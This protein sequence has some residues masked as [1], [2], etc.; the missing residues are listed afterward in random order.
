MP[1]VPGV[2]PISN[3]RQVIRM[4]ELSGAAIPDELLAK[5]DS[6]EN[7]VQARKI[8]MDYA[9]QLAIDL[10]AAGAPGIHIFTLNSHTAAIELARGA[11]LCR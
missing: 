1:I 2:M 9:T 4:A 6:A 7:E 3:A 8:G 5:F 10:I 11:G